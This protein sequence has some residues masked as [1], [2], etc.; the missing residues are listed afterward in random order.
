MSR[1]KRVCTSPPMC[2]QHEQQAEPRGSCIDATVSPGIAGH[3]HTPQSLDLWPPGHA[4]T[5]PPAKEARQAL[6][7]PQCPSY[8]CSWLTPPEIHVP[9]NTPAPLHLGTHE[10]SPVLRI[11]ALTREL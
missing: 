7:L 2:H 5:H 11:H 1:L 10:H 3:P 8:H 9:T 4:Q 6:T